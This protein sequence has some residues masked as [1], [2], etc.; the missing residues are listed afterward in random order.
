MAKNVKNVFK[1]DVTAL[2]PSSSDLPEVTMTVTPN[3]HIQEFD[4][5]TFSCEADANPAE[6]TWT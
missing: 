5:M 1:M 2:I 6:V 3:R 4:S